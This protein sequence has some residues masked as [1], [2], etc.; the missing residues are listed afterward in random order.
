MCAARRAACAARTPRPAPSA[1]A[2]APAPAAVPLGAAGKPPAA[3][4]AG[5]RGS[6]RSAAL[7]TLTPRTGRWG[8][9]AGPGAPARRPPPPAAPGH[10]RPTPPPPPRPAPRPAPAPRSCL[11]LLQKK[12][13]FWFT[14]FAP[15]RP[16][17]GPRSGPFGARPEPRTR[18]A[19]DRWVAGPASR[20]AFPG[21]PHPCAQPGPRSCRRRRLW[22]P[23]PLRGSHLGDP[24][25]PGAGWNPFSSCCSSDRSWVERGCLSPGAALA[26]APQL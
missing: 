21:Q 7:P 9:G 26:P 24:V 20:C 19:G 6:P 2:P 8:G 5:P 22:R 23:L 11:L 17:P 14:A 16:P 15:P 18:A 10:P 1:P 4:R 13:P 12:S 3:P 25:R